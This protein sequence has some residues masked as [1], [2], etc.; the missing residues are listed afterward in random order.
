MKHGIKNLPK[1]I[2][3]QKGSNGQ[4]GET[5]VL[6]LK[7]DPDEETPFEH[8]LYP[9]AVFFEKQSTKQY[10]PLLT[11]DPEVNLRA[12]TGDSMMENIC[13]KSQLPSSST[14]S[15]F[16]AKVKDTI[17][18]LI[19]AGEVIEADGGSDSGSDASDDSQD[20]E[21]TGQGEGDMKK[22]AALSWG[23]TAANPPL[24]G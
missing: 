20:L 5:K 24:P 2:K 21:G 22:S 13:K 17:G 15:G 3:C 7:R 4:G 6:Y 11:N 18:K 12:E 8:Q 14:V 16:L 23:R 19:K 9:R 1:T 10:T